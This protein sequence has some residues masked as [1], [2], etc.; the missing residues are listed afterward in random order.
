MGDMPF[1][2]YGPDMYQV[3]LKTMLLCAVTC[4]PPSTHFYQHAQGLSLNIDDLQSDHASN[5]TLR[6][7]SALYM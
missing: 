5:C 7:W 2:L 1:A 6:V 4:K 3:P